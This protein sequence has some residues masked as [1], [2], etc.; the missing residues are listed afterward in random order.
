MMYNRE[1]VTK[2]T[3]QKGW[4][5]LKI[6]QKLFGKPKRNTAFFRLPERRDNWL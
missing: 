6:R 3:K 2:K 4:N 1:P 5:F